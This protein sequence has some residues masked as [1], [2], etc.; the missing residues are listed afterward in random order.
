[1]K[2]VA[3]QTWTGW[4]NRL[5]PTLNLWLCGTRLIIALK[6]GNV[7]WEFMRSGKTCQQILSIDEQ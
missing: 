2:M 5:I 7:L 1:M 3:G 6:T 4:R